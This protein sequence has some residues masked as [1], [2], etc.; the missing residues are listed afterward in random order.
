MRIMLKSACRSPHLSLAFS[1]GDLV[2]EFGSTDSASTETVDNTNNPQIEFGE[3]NFFASFGPGAEA[4]RS[5]Q[6]LWLFLDDQ[7]QSGGDNHDDLVIRISAVPLPAGALLLL[8]GMGA[9]A[10]RRKRS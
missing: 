3:M 2:F 10:L 8:S 7:G 1:A 6:V 9:L 4:D 5:G